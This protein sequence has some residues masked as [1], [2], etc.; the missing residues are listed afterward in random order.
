LR[1]AGE[2]V[3]PLDIAA[4]SAAGIAKVTIRAPRIALARAS[5]AKTAMLD[6]A[7]A[8]LVRC[9]AQNGG[10]PITQCN[11]AETLRSGECDA[12]IGIGGTGT[13]RRDDAVHDLA[14]LGRV[15]AHGI[16]VSPGDTAAFGFTGERPV[17]LVPGRL[18][19]ALAVWLQIGRHLVAKLAGGAIEDRPTVLSLG[20]KVTST[21]GLTE[22]IAMRC[23]SDSVEP[24]GAGYLSLTALAHSDGWITVPAD[25]EGFAAGSLVAVNRWP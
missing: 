19:A 20:R 24:I 25:S 9:I 3:R 12:A 22:L 6:A 14:R 21:L 2:I 7:Y 18:D 15:E 5:A 11:L 4:M 10:V 16:A 17:L 23:S 8:T 13:G 1:R